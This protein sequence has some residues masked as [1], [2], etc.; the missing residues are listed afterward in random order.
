MFW[1]DFC[2]KISENNKNNRKMSTS[3]KT[4]KLFIECKKPSSIAINNADG[5]PILNTTP[6][7]ENLISKPCHLHMINLSGRPSV[8]QY[9]V[10]LTDEENPII[11][12][13]EEDEENIENCYPILKTSDQA[14][15]G[16]TKITVPEISAYV[17][18]LGGTVIN[19]VIAG[20][21]KHSLYPDLL[22]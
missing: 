2:K 6:E 21:A 14:L 8:G 16:I 11:K 19:H 9:C 4:K 7:S 18:K 13:L 12:K 1:N 15:V 5:L 22:K 10:D 17:E 20:C 3:I